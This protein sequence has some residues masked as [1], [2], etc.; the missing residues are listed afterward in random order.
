MEKIELRTSLQELRDSI[1]LAKKIW[2]HTQ[3]TNCYA[4]ALGIDKDYHIDTFQPGAISGYMITPPFSY[5]ELIRGMIADFNALGIDYGSAEPSEPFQDGE[6]KIAVLLEQTKDTRFRNYHFLR[7]REDGLWYH[8]K[9]YG[10][11]ITKLDEYGTIIT[12]P[13]QARFKQIKYDSCFHLKLK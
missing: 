10:G 1:D 8:K 6:W 3:R 2:I 12:T 13:E 9:G 7:Q 4:Y 5:T 11:G